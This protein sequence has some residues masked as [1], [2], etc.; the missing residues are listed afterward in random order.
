M[1]KLFSNTVPAA[2]TPYNQTERTN[3]LNNICAI[4]DEDQKRNRLRTFI[5]EETNLANANGLAPTSL[6][7]RAQ[8]TLLSL[9][10]IVPELDV[11]MPG[12]ALNEM[13]MPRSAF[14]R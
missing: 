14:Q 7:G 8:R 5:T 9:E 2:P 10:S 3:Q 1:V 12:P 4:Q 11:H 13:D 6:L